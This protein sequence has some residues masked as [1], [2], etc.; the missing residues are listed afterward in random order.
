MDLRRRRG[1]ATNDTRDSNVEAYIA[2]TIVDDSFDG[3]SPN[4]KRVTKGKT[5]DGVDDGGFTQSSSEAA[6]AVVGAAVRG[7][8][9]L[10]VLALI[11]VWAPCLEV[12]PEKPCQLPGTYVPGTRYQQGT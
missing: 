6:D 9:L 2:R 5:E 3:L 11:Q 8:S 1:D 4:S 10:M 7:G 12:A